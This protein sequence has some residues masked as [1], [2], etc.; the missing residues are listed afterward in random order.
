MTKS[1]KFFTIGMAFSTMLFSGTAIFGQGLKARVIK[2]GAIMKAE[3]KKDKIA[4]VP[5]SLGSRLYEIEVVKDWT[6][7][8]IHPY[9]ADID[10]GYILSEFLESKKNEIP[11]FGK[12]DDTEIRRFSERE[13]IRIGFGASYGKSWP[14]T[15]EAVDEFSE[16]KFVDSWVPSGSIMLRF[17]TGFALEVC[18]KKYEM[19]LRENDID[20][21]TIN[22][23][24]IGL[25]LKY[26]GMPYGD[27]G[28][29]SH[30]DV[31]I[32]INFSN[33]QKGS[34]IEELEFLTG[35]DLSI[36]TP[37]AFFV[38]MG[39]GLDIFLGKF[40]SIGLEGRLYMGN[41]KST[42]TYSGPAATV[43]QEYKLYV[44][45]AQVSVGL[46]FWI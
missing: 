46:R 25:H 33:F 10:L 7:D 23:T 29:T 18:A 5:F 14:V 32:G 2:E 12:Q 8:Q 31:G 13:K 26:Q 38:D 27:F 6:K 4:I 39:A 42:W 3:P 24:P 44:S 15:E 11:I 21:G 35:V 1:F 9:R 43:S 30:V 36:D 40:I 16:T 37:D 41:I 19:V 28:V 17:P 45:N 20:F 22:Q 34:I